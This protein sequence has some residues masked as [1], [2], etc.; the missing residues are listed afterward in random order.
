MLSGSQ[1]VDQRSY[2]E[3]SNLDTEEKQDKVSSMKKSFNNIDQNKI[4]LNQ[5]MAKFEQ[6]R[7][8]KGSPGMQPEQMSF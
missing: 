6:Y 8:P 4:L 7:T 5:L 1:Y 2:S 3:E